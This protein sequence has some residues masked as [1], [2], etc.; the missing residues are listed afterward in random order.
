MKKRGVN[1]ISLNTLEM[2]RHCWICNDA[3]KIMFT[4]PLSERTFSVLG[5]NFDMLL[6]VEPQGMCGRKKCLTGSG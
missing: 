4:K 6:A 1:Q 2:C 5:E 3:E